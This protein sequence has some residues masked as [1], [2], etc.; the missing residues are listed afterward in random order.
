[1]I[2]FFRRLVPQTYVDEEEKRSEIRF[3][4]TILIV[5]IVGV[6]AI[7]I[8]DGV[9]GGRWYLVYTLTPLALLLLG[10]TILLTRNV[11]LLAKFLVPVSIFAVLIYTI[12]VGGGI[13]DIAMVA[14]ASLLV[15]ASL[16]LGR[17]AALIFGVLTSIYVFILGILEINKII[18]NEGSFITTIDE[19]ILYSI[20]ILL[21]AALLRILIGRLNESIISA[22]SNELAQMQ[23]NKELLDLQ[24][25][26]EQRVDERTAELSEANRRNEQR[27]S[28]FS[29]IAQIGK[30]VASVQNIDILLPR[31]AGLISERFGFYH[32]GIFLLDE[33]KEFAVLRAANSAGG[34]K[35]LA[36]NHRLRVGAEGLV[37]YATGHA[38]ARI[39]LD[40]GEDVVFFDNPD[41]PDTRSEMAL[42]LVIGG[43]AI[44]ALDVQ[45][46]HSNAFS[47]ED[48]QVLSTLADQVAVAIQNARLFEQS[49]RTAQELENALRRYLQ[50]EWG[51]YSAISSLKGYRAHEEG[52]EPI[53][54]S[55]KKTGRKAKKRAV[56]QFPI[57]L[58]GVT[59]GNLDIDLGKQSKGITQEENDIIQA[60]AERV[61]LALEGARLLETSQRQAAKEQLISEMTAK[62][63]ASI[64]MRNVLQTAVEELGKSI[65]GSEI[66]IQFQSNQDK[67]REAQS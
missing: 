20:L 56:H 10:T 59:I 32:V 14:F 18:V 64:N 31:V 46:E 53:A 29:A 19:L 13:H 54:D 35:M 37:G 43:E 9:L 6:V 16:T 2:D 12:T 65:P 50:N 5:I 39:A 28:Q 21:T 55:A 62:I 7:T 15:I 40:V 17:S 48:I 27:A 57:T 4:R 38:R 3:L 41:L 47:E 36:R 66:V 22:R 42:P 63:G 26:L 34:Q 44:G 11:I 49:Q 33:N 30:I 60:T 23:V 61:A 24:A 51:Q 25:T 8:S 1:M 58:R 45:S 67:S 52:L